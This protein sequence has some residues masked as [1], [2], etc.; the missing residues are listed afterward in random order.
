MPKPNDKIRLILNLKKFNESEANVHFKMDNI[1]TVLKLITKNCWMA[2]IDLKDAYYSV[3][4]DPLYQKYLKFS[5]DND[6]YQFTAFPN[7]LSTCP[8][9]F[10]KLLKPALAYLRVEGYIIMAYIDDLY[11]QGRTLEECVQNVIQTMKILESLGFVVHPDK[12][13]FIPSHRLIFLGFVLDSVKMTVTLTAEKR[14]KLKALIQQALSNPSQIQIRTVA[15]LI[16]HFVSCLPAVRHGALYYRQLDKNKTTALKSNKGNFDSI[17]S[18]SASG[19]QELKWWLANIDTSFGYITKPPIDLVIYTDASLIGWGAALASQKT[20]GN[21]SASETNI[22]INNLELKAV[23]FALKCFVADIETKHVKLMIDNSAAVYMIN[24]MGSSH[25]KLGNSIVVD[26]WEFCI[27]KHIWITAAHVPGVENVVAD[28]EPRKSYRDS[29]WMINSKEL[30]NCLSHLDF[31][32]DIDL[33]ACR[34]NAQFPIYCSYRP[35]PGAKYVNAF[36]IK[37]DNLQF[38]CFPPFSCILQVIQKIIL[39]KACGIL[40]V[41]NWP[42]QPWYPLLNRILIKTPQI[43][44]P[45]KYLLHLPAAPDQLHPLHQSLQLKICLVS[46]H[47]SGN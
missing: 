12:S 10:T 17:M 36:T 20:G 4:V 7:G 46:G 3:K 29:E 30:Q 22:H 21:W 34:L 47:K 43:L 16:G 38:Y 40:V 1:Q 18:I 41:P 5:F 33:F 24:N 9:Q 8:R 28:R 23:L 2:S 19:Q 25:S 37:W 26:I 32:P 39:E 35:D 6:L 44:L 14:E 45:S 13:V 42:T 31:K 27:S 11:L 15:Q